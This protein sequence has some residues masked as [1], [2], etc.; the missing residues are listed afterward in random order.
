M[1]PWIGTF[2][3]LPRFTS[4]SGTVWLR[5]CWKRHIQKHQY[6]SGGADW[7][8]QYRRFAP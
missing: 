3:W 1:G 2:A 5:R 6:L 8:W 7:W 4:D